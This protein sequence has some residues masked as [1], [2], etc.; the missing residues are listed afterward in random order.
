MNLRGR[1]CS[2]HPTPPPSWL[3][4]CNGVSR[5][6]IR[7]KRGSLL[8][9]QLLFIGQQELKNLYCLVLNNFLRIRSDIHSS[10][11]FLGVMFLF[12]MS[13]KYPS[14]SL[15]VYLYVSLFKTGKISLYYI[16]IVCSV[17]CFTFLL[18]GSYSPKI[19]SPLPGIHIC[20][21]P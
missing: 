11:V 21:F 19:S 20:F 18:C 13:F 9:G 15:S 8:L 14:P 2:P 16:F 17:P 10:A 5:L 3:L 4:P 12:N 6:K 7:R 1:K